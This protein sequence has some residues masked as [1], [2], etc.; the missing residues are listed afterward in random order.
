MQV[1]IDELQLHDQISAEEFLRQREE[2]LD[3]LFPTAQLMPGDPHHHTLDHSK[4]S[5]P[6]LISCHGTLS[7][8]KR[9]RGHSNALSTLGCA[10]VDRLIRHLHQHKVP[11]AV[12]TSSHRRHFDVKTQ[13]HQQLFGLFDVIVTGDQ[14]RWAHASCY[15]VLLGPV[16]CCCAGPGGYLGMCAVQLV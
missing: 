5:R 6:G 15:V 1:L 13:Q 14:V 7:R 9:S 12:A 8:M 16:E 2:Q 4:L 3:K 11:I 10:G